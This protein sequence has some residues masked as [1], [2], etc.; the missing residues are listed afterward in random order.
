[1]FLVLFR[2]KSGI[3]VDL[4]NARLT[5]DRVSWVVPRKQGREKARAGSRRTGVRRV[6]GGE[7]GGERA[8]QVTVASRGAAGH[9]PGRHPPAP[10]DPPKPTVAADARSPP[11]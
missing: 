7:R 11:M 10:R 4:A 9:G 5:G 2:R 3:D 1:M 6:G 8:R